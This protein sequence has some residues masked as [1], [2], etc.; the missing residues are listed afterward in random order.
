RPWATPLLGPI[1]PMVSSDSGRGLTGIPDTHTHTHT[2]LQHQRSGEINYRQSADHFVVVKNNKQKQ[3]LTSGDQPELVL[4]VSNL[5]LLN[6]SSRE[7]KSHHSLEELV[8]ELDGERNHVDL[9]TETETLRD[10]RERHT[11]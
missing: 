2:Q 7:E 9:R 3:K 8:H 5:F 4:L 10:R 6:I 1:I 11:H